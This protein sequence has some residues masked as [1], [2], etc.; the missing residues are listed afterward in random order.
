[1]I[2]SLRTRMLCGLGV[3]IITSCV[4]A[5]VWEFRRSFHEA[6]ELQDAILLQIGFI[7]IRNHALDDFTPQPS[8]DTEARVVVRQIPDRFA[9]TQS[10]SGFPSLPMDL[11]DGLHTLPGSDGL[12]RVLVRT[13]RDGSRVAIE[14]STTA[15]NEIARDSAIRAVLPMLA[16]IPCLMVVVG[17][18]IHYSFRPVIDLAKKLD[19]DGTEHPLPIPVDSA[20]SELQPFI[21]SINR[22]LDRMAVLLDHQR[23]FVALSAHELRTPI[24]AISIQAENVDV[25]QLPQET[26]NRLEALKEGVQRTVRL[27][28]QLLTLSKYDY[29]KAPPSS[30]VMLDGV[31]KAVVADFTVPASAQ[32]IDLG[33]AR[34]ETG[35]VI[36]GDSTALTI[37][38][39]NLVDNA[40]RYTPGGGKIN[41][42]VYRDCDSVILLVEDTGS[43]IE[44]G[45][46]DVVFEPFNRGRLA[47]G[48]GT[49]L[50]LSIV[51]RI[52][53]SH[54]GTISIQNRTSPATAGL[55]VTVRLPAAL[56]HH[57]A[58][59]AAANNKC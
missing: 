11:Q 21:A 40:V 27:L 55:L 58:S 53:D 59:Q 6:I 19:D 7:A 9:A 37:M 8:I 14:Q 32:A 41:L 42:S 39:R 23:R 45:D 49:G 25:G 10:G 22:L 48:G 44:P 46:L 5:G 16:L 17:G 57:L 36:T 20:P 54:G 47:K 31:V 38:V 3:L 13:R 34:I 29:G 52:L 4:G 26:R 28:E 24:T 1:M 2:K 33:C 18:V 50:G 30:A 56:V 51:R 35:V 15:R 12:W 43:G